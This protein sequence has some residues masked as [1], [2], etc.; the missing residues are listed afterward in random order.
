MIISPCFCHY[1][2]SLVFHTTLI[3]RLASS[4]RHFC[5]CFGFTLDLLISAN[6]SSFG[7]FLISW[8]KNT[9]QA[10]FMIGG[11]VT[12]LGMAG[13][14]PTFTAGMPNPPSFIQ[15]ISYCTPQ[16]WAVDGLNTTM[17]GGGLPDVMMNILVLVG[18]AIVLFSIGV[19]RFRNR[20]K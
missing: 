6:N 18:W 20:Y 17:T 11:M 4:F 9:R 7:V 5:L 13:M 2:L 16:G 12:I 19:I 10:G 15:T 14:M 3:P 1:T 8:M